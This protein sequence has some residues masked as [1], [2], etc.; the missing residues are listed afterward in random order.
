MEQTGKLRE[1]EIN[2]LKV[3]SKLRKKLISSS[4]SETIVLDRNKLARSS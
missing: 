3:K 2:K 4:K 1:K